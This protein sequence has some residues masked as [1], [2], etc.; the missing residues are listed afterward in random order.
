MQLLGILV[1][2]FIFCSAKSKFVQFDSEEN[3]DVDYAYFDD[4]FKQAD[5]PQEG[6]TIIREI[7]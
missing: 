3:E 1:F 7:R 6:E 2:S 5:E 4:Y